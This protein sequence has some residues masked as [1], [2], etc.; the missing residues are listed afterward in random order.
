MSKRIHLTKTKAGIRLTV[1][2]AES[3]SD[4]IRKAVEASGRSR[5]GIC[6]AIG[7]AEA[8]MSRFMNRKGGLSMASLDRLAELIGLVVVANP[9]ARKAGE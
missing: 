4:Q 3:F 8:T 5:Y 6:K 1:M 9:T 2:G 7:V